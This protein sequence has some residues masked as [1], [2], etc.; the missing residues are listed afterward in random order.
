MIDLYRNQ[1]SLLHHTDA[2]VKFIFTLAFLVCLNLSPTGAWPAYVLFFA[3]LIIELLLSQVPIKIVLLRSIIS[4]PFLLAAFPL[5]FAGQDPFLKLNSWLFVSQPG[6]IRFVSITFKSW[7]SILA[8][9]L[10]T[11]TTT[12]QEIMSALRY[13]GIP[14]TIMAILS[15]MWR[16]LSL[17]INEA[18]T[19]MEARNSRSGKQDK[20]QKVGGSLGWRGKVTGRLAGNLLLRSLERSERVYA[21]MVSRG[22]NGEII[23]TNNHS[24]SF[25]GVIPAMI[26]VIFCVVILGIALLLH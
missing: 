6:L 7:M 18:L 14:Q 13:L 9:I 24:F 16:Y 3:L 21:A 10:L 5:L 22:Y 1:N 11:C 4:L 17:M 8:A 20:N 19:L 25:R 26:G 15:L 23:Q 12:F 2:R